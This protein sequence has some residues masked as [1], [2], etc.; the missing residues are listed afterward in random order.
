MSGSTIGQVLGIG[1]MVVAVAA[2]VVTSGLHAPAAGTAAATRAAPYL[3]DIETGADHVGADELARELLAARG[4]V[5]V[6]DVRPAE[7]F[8]AWHLPGA[9]NLTVPEVVGAAGQQLLAGKPRLLVLCSN[10]PAH[11]AQAWVELRRQGH[12][13][14][15]VLD[16]GL[17]AFK[18]KVLT[19][20]SLQPG[21]DEGQI[22]AA[23]MGFALRRAFFLAAAKPNP[24]A[25]WATDPAELTAP[26]V[27]S[28]KWLQQRLGKVAIVDA[29]EKAAEYADLHL[30]GAVHL[31]VASLRSKAG[32][33]D[34]HLLSPRELAAKFGAVG[35]SRTTPVVIYAEDKMQDATMAA[36]AFVQAGHS[37]LAILEGGL[38]RWATEKR[39]LVADV[40]APAAV[41]YEPGRDAAV[42]LDTDQV[43]AQWRAGTAILD[44][45]P[46][47]G[48]TGAKSTEARPGH[49]PGARNRVFT[50]DLQRGD[51]G[52]WFRPRAE[53]EAEY[54]ALGL[55]ADQPVVV[56]CR[57]GHTASES[58]FVLRYLLGYRQAQFYNGSWTE[59]AARTDLPAATG[60]GSKD[61]RK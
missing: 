42:S 21:A 48:F 18:A 12:T 51:D 28:T 61:E 43:A 5:V 52:H 36:L 15:R 13:N 60:D 3:Q 38:L 14:V 26:T 31:P 59:W 27:V 34:L 30:P 55:R 47:E 39:S 53:L 46:A 32:D 22:R 50:K 16:G 49:I 56:S 8:A 58:Y 44:V 1:V 24:L 37:A 23:A 2:V 9:R 10:G 41:V 57:T 17:D 7:E 45:R 33:R 6:V 4:D 54:G 40:P 25:A 11:P 29:R 35:I 19:P 20:A